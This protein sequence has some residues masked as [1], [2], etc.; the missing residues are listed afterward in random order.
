M[1]YQKIINLLE[2]TSDQSSKFRTKNWV[3]INDELGRAY[4]TNSQIK[5]ETTILKSSLCNYSGTYI[6]VKLPITITGD[7]GPKPYA[8]NQITAAQ[9]LAARH[10]DER[11]KGVIFKN[12]APFINCLIEINNTQ[13]K[14]LKV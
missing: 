1:E 3:E 12:C 5:F 14:E 11:S 7:A 8:N 13:M 2:N 4:N 10:T 6:L 9:L